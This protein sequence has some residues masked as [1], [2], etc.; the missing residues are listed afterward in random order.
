MRY[1]SDPMTADTYNRLVKVLGRQKANE[2]RDRQYRKYVVSFSISLEAKDG[3]KQIATQLSFLKGGT[4][5]GSEANA[6]VSSLIEAIGLGYAWVVI[7]TPEELRDRETVPDEYPYVIT[8]PTIDL[9]DGH[10]QPRPIE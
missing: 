10:V 1:S 7:P 3:L 5:P 4:Q 9:S 8:R 2:Y 6:N